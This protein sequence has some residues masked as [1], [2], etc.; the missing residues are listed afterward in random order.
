MGVSLQTVTPE[1]AAELGMKKAEGVVVTNVEQGGLAGEA[2]IQRGDVILEVD[3][4]PVNSPKEFNEVVKKAD[5]SLLFLV[6]R[7][8]ATFY[9]TIRISPEGN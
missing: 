9:V 8:A 6:Y 1:I 3:R 7:G 5:K 4:N 2:G